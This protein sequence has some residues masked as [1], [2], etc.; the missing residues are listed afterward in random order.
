[1]VERYRD[2]ERGEGDPRAGYHWMESYEARNPGVFA[3]YWEHVLGRGCTL[4]D[5]EQAAAYWRPLA[6]R[7][8]AWM[9][10]A[11]WQTWRYRHDLVGYRKPS[12]AEKRAAKEA[13]AGQAA[14]SGNGQPIG[15]PSG[16]GEPAPDSRHRG[17]APQVTVPAGQQTCPYC[18]HTVYGVWLSDPLMAQ[19]V[20][21]YALEQM[22]LTLGASG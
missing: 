6:E 9:T 10:V 3:W 2:P 1:M 18:G 20:Q 4:A 21:A 8:G 16:G 14:A 15:P 5:D 7:E 11:T 19:R 17:Q 13:M 12:Y 22:R